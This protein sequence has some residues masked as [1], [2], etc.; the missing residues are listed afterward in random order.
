MDSKVKKARSGE[1]TSEKVKIIGSTKRGDRGETKL[2]TGERVTKSHIRIEVGGN[3]DESNAAM[4]LAKALTQNEEIRNIIAVVQKD[5][6]TLG[7]EVSSTDHTRQT[8]H[9]EQE[10]IAR[11]EKWIKDL[12]MEAPLPRRFIDPGANPV[13]A[14]LDLARSIVRRTERSMVL[15]QETGQ[16][17]REETLAYVNRLACLLFTLARYAEKTP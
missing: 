13:S 10:H 8:K 17:E 7:A 6:I 16:L 9:I 4:G 2:L 11:I 15:L 5:L 1:K 14:V 12:Q 3:L